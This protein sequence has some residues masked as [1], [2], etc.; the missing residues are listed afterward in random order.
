MSVS[1]PEAA[2]LPEFSIWTEITNVSA[3]H[4][5]RASRLVY[6]RDLLR[7]LVTRDLKLR[8][9]RSVLGMA[10]AV[11]T[12]LA[13][14]VIFTF[15]FS[16]VM[17][18]N[19]PNYTQFVFCGVL[20]WS[21]FQSSMFLAAVSI[22]DNRDLVRRPGFPVAVLPVVT[23]ATNLVQYLLAL[24]VLI[25]FLL[26]D[27]GG[28][29]PTIL[30]LPL[31]L[32]VQFILTLGLSYI[33]A[34]AYVAFRDIQHILNVGLTLMFYLTPVFYTLDTVPEQYRGVY[35]LNPMAVLLQSYRDVIVVG[36]LPSLLPLALVAAASAVLLAVGYSF[37]RRASDRF[38]EEL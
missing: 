23:V 1:L 17:P 7:E 4:L 27:G 32:L 10:W 21:W 19:I 3:L 29:H 15:L 38:V 18:L 13:Q 9:K 5:T 35:M 34:A 12:P 36:V 6:V 8:Y 33:V 24:P 22:V 28:L 26:R 30:A 20:A 14:I 25:I 37:F 2:R 11:I 31:V 16:R